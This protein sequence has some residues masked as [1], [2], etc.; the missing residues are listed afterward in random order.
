VVIA[1]A[2]DRGDNYLHAYIVPCEPPDDDLNVS[3]LRKYL[4]KDLPGYMIPPYFIRLTELPLTNHGKLDKAVL[5]S[6]GTKG[7]KLAT[8]AE[9][10]APGSKL[11]KK[12]AAAWREVLKVDKISIYDN[13][14]DLGGTSLGIILLVNKLKEM[15]GFDVPV[16]SM[17]EYPTIESFSRHMNQQETEE[18]FFE[19]ELDIAKHRMEKTFQKIKE[20]RKNIT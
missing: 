19:D 6:Y 16:T 8:G 17:F 20:I 15:V 4:M 7:T 11:E 5:D 18:S 10:V 14:F 2:N 9:Y 13:F 12:I 3:K 1:K